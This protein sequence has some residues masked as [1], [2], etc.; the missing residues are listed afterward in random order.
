M[1]LDI[2]IVVTFREECGDND[3]EGA[4][5]CASKMLLIF[6]FFNFSGGYM[7]TFTL[8]THEFALFCTNIIYKQNGV[9]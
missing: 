6:H 1:I 9:S 3:W 7:N 2:K 4:R 8:N 5:G